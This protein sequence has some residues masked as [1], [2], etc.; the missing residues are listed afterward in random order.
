MLQPGVDGVSV[1]V[2]EVGGGVSF[3]WLLDV[4]SEEVAGFGWLLVS[5]LVWVLEEACACDLGAGEMWS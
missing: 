3:G 1:V 4:L 5:V 2:E